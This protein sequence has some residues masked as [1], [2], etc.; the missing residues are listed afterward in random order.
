MRLT[1]RTGADE[2]ARAD[3][4]LLAAMG[5]PGGGVVRL[6]RTHALVAPGPV[7][8]PNELVVSAEVLAN[9]GLGA[10]ASVDAVR[11]RLPAAVRVTFAGDA[12]PADPRHLA[13]SLHGRPLTTGDR[14]TI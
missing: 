13:R 3:A 1:I 12:L 14:I 10:G 8:S 2:V 4:D 5:L 6:G 7:R 9:S 11:M